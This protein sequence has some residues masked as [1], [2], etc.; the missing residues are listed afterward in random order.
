VPPPPLGT[1][2]GNK[3]RRIERNHRALGEHVGAPDPIADID[4]TQGRKGWP[5]SRHLATVSEHYTTLTQM[6]SASV[7]IISITQR[8]AL[9]LLGCHHVD[10][11]ERA[12]LAMVAES[13]S[14]SASMAASRDLELG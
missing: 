6:A 9:G 7:K 13:F 2:T 11:A 1:E 14:I 10:R 5:A 8:R 3:R 4:A 12:V